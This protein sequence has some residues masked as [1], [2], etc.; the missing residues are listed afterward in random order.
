VIYAKMG[1]TKEAIIDLE[2]ALRV[3]PD[4]KSLHQTLAELYEALGDSEL[5]RQHRAMGMSKDSGASHP[6]N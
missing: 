2:F 6:R 1:K 4:R 3:F 5:A